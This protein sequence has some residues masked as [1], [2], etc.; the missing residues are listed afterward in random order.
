MDRS[1]NQNAKPDSG[2]ASASYRLY[3]HLVWP[4]KYRKHILGEKLTPVVEEKIV[5]VCEMRGYELI[6]ARAVVDHVHVLLGY[7]PVHRV[8]DIM[9]DLKANSSKAAFDQF[10]RL[11]EII[12]MDVLWAEGY[13]A[14]SISQGDLQ[15]VKKYIENQAKHHRDKLRFRARQDAKNVDYGES[16]ERGEQSGIGQL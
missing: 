6:I 3:V 10:E 14:D 8:C 9:R 4:T 16:R 2:H 13:R 7:K 11:K 15:G 1:P 5:E 12:R